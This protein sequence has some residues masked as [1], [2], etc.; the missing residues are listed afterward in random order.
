MRVG[1]YRPLHDV[2]EGGHLFAEGGAVKQQC[3]LCPPSSSSS[4]SP[5][6]TLHTLREGAQRR[7]GREGGGGGREGGGGGGGGGEGGGGGGEGGGGEGG[8]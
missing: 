5:S 8:S 6:P 2:P 4:P 7:G 1:C 3:P